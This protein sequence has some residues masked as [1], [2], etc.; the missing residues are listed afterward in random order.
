MLAVKSANGN[1]GLIELIEGYI[2]AE[3]PVGSNTI[4]DAT[5][6]DAT[7]DI[8]SGVLPGDQVHISGTTTIY[9]VLS[10]TDDNTLEM[11]APIAAAHTNV[12]YKIKRGGIGQSAIKWQ[13][14]QDARGSDRWIVFYEAT[15]FTV[16]PPPP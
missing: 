5:F 10:K 14:F 1:Q 11:T 16:T 9:T 2:V 3:S 15:T 12:S 8:F 7:A 13:P 6:T 4:A